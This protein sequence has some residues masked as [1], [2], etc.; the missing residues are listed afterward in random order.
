MNKIRSDRL[1]ERFAARGQEYVDKLLAD[2]R[3]A[4][5]MF[6]MRCGPEHD[7]FWATVRPS[8]IVL[9][10]RC[11]HDANR[12]E[13]M[14]IRNA[15]PTLSQGVQDAE[16]HRTM[17]RYARDRRMQLVRGQFVKISKREWEAEPVE[18]LTELIMQ[19]Y[20]Q[21]KFSPE[22]WAKLA[23]LHAEEIQIRRGSGKK[24]DAAS[25]KN[26]LSGALTAWGVY[27]DILWIRQQRDEIFQRTFPR[28]VS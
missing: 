1:P 26:S 19:E 16:L 3:Y 13:A 28:K 17:L 20:D 27:D 5:S 22:D 7:R 4:A 2:C 11:T 23:A 21:S 25:R 15:L 9:H 12:S 24:I 8:E 14:Q 10:L 6:W 18:K